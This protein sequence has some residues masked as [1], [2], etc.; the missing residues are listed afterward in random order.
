MRLVAAT[1]ER[2]K[3]LEIV[4]AGIFLPAE[5]PEEGYD[6]GLIALMTERDKGLEN[7]C[8]GIFVLAEASVCVL[9]ASAGS[10]ESGP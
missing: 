3:R 8:A 4:D 1:T 7:V 2:V 9:G 6:T 5:A 10:S